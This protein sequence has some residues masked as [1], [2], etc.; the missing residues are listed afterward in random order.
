MINQPR[1]PAHIGQGLAFPLF[2]N[3]QGNWALSAGDRNVRESILL[4]LM[5]NI[6]ER[7]N[8][9]EFGCRLWELSF[10]PINSETLMLMRIFVQEA[11]EQWEPRIMLRDVEAIPDPDGGRVDLVINYSL[12]PSEDKRSLVYPFYLQKDPE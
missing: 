7:V 3:Q 6:G 5:T 9:P 1:F 12:K 8:R 2:V 10:A 11:L 4:I